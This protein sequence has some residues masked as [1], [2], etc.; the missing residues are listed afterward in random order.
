MRVVLILLSVLLAVAL[1]FSPRPRNWNNNHHRG[2]VST[3]SGQTIEPSSTTTTTQLSVVWT[4]IF[5]SAE[6]MA[7][8]DRVQMQG[9]L[10]TKERATRQ[11]QADYAAQLAMEARARK[12]QPPAAVTTVVAVEETTAEKEE[13]RQ[14]SFLMILQTLYAPWL[15]VFFRRFS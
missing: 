14:S 5:R 4:R 12:Y 3:P 10:A 9:D 15:G 8:Q 11:R 1:G 7:Y 13:R 6:E 2:L